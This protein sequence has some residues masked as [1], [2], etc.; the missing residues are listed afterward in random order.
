MRSRISGSTSRAAASGA[1][2]A[3]RRSP[4][5]SLGQRG[6][7]RSARGLRGAAR[8]RGLER[9][10]PGVPPRGRDDPRD[11][12]PSTTSSARDGFAELRGIGPGIAARLG[13]LVE[14][15]TIAELD[16]LEREVRPGAD[17]LGRYLGVAPKRMLEIAAE[18]GVRLRTSFARRPLPGGCSTV[19]GIG[20]ATERRLVE[21]LRT[22]AE[23]SPAAPPPRPG[24]RARGADRAALDG[25]VAGDARRWVAAPH[26][27]VVVV[28]AA[29]G[30]SRCSSVCG[31][32]R[33][34]HGRRAGER[35]AV[36]VT[37]EG[38]PVTL[39]VAEPGAPRDRAPAR[40]RQRRIRRG[41]RAAPRG[42]RRG[43]RLPRRS[44]SRGARRSCARR[45]FGL[46]AASRRARRR[47]RRPSLPHHVVGRQ[48]NRAGDGARGDRA[49]LRVHRDLRPH[50]E[51]ARRPGP[52]RRR[53][54]QTGRGDR[55]GRTRSWR[56]SASSA[57]PR[58]TSG[59]T[60]RSTSPTTCW[61]SSTGCSS[62]STRASGSRASS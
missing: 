41:A 49:R 50:A 46:A 39:L 62:A 38:I 60:G 48:G 8:P 47:P 23:P 34:R 37:V 7:S 53:S 27:L 20:P 1:E 43:G 15:G 9:L 55:G 31:A 12:S 40:D 59:R 17:G 4:L 6:D 35:R 16:E 5:A 58:S 57:A 61:P 21:R 32:P 2:P 30:P 26:E 51:R 24:A 42:G 44:G 19:R 13:E 11:A 18:L 56:R 33:C 29:D 52:R 36:G 10:Q 45:R 14:T 25:E 28:A 3:A 54:P 22:G